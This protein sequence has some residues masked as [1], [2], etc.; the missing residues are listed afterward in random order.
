MHMADRGGRAMRK[1][2]IRHTFESCGL[3]VE[4]HPVN[5]TWLVICPDGRIIRGLNNQKV[6]LNRAKRYLKSRGLCQQRES[7]R[8]EVTDKELSR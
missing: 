1:I 5:G 8:V 4:Q 7:S 3:V 2:I 6:A